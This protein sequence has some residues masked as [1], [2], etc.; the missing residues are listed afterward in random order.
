MCQV[1]VGKAD[2][3]LRAQLVLEQGCDLI[4][5]ELASAHGLFRNLPQ[6]QC[7]Q[8]IVESLI[9]GEFDLV[10]GC[11]GIHVRRLGTQCGSR[12]QVIGAS[13]VGNQLR[14]REPAGGALIHNRVT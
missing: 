10:G 2:V 13:K 8:R 12:D 3:E 5:H 14:K 9:D 1:G 6:S 7:L 4:G 11:Q